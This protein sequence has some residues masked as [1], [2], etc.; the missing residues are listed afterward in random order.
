[1]LAFPCRNSPG[2]VRHCQPDKGTKLAKGAGHTVQRGVCP[3]TSV[4]TTEAFAKIKTTQAGATR[5]FAPELL[6]RTESKREAFSSKRVTR[7]LFRFQVSGF[8]AGE[9]GSPG[10]KPPAGSAL[11]PSR[12]RSRAGA[13]LINAQLVSRRRSVCLQACKMVYELLL[14]ISTA[15]GH[16]EGLG[17]M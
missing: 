14:S 4:L 15:P 16:C 5:L 9:S 17:T 7:A 2:R 12:A 3:R 8:Q 6:Q 13:C 1:M 11:R 10:T